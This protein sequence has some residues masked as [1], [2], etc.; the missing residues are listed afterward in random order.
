MTAGLTLTTPSTDL[1]GSGELGLNLAT[2]RPDTIGLAYT[3]QT[4]LPASYKTPLSVGGGLGLPVGPVKIH[5]SA[6]WFA[7]IDRY[8]VIQGQTI[9]AK[10]AE[11]IE[12]PIDAVHEGDEVLNWG[13]GAEFQVSRRFI[14]FVSYYQ[15]NSTL[16]SD[17][18]RS[19][20]AI[21][22]FDIRTVTA[23]TEFTA[24]P[25]LLTLGAGYGWGEEIDTELTNVID[26]EGE[27]GLQARFVFRSLR[28]LFGFQVGI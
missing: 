7:R 4:D 11:D 10:E 25:A 23:G 27:E 2:F 22:P 16:T 28:V 26:P 13:V 15:D 9:T 3:V 14:G 12:I 18:E 24:G 1:T 19:S 17:I 8:V 6:E 5:A 21:M 20:L